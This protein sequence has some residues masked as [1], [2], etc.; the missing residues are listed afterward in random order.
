MAV[1]KQQQRMAVLGL[2]AIG[3][4]YGWQM[5]KFAADTQMRRWMPLGL[6]TIYKVLKDLE[7]DGAV[8]G[9]QEGGGRGPKR[10]AHVLTERGRAEFEDGVVTAL[11]SDGSVY[12]DRMAGLVFAPL[13]RESMALDAM[14]DADD[15]LASAEVALT[16]SAASTGT[17]V[18]A[19]AIITFYREVHAA[20][21]K[22]LARVKGFLDDRQPREG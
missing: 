6:S 21:R 2:L 3:M 17:D 4:R 8:E 13:L 16:D 7:R 22:A 12:S 11:R 14:Q 10:K 15:W 20:E 1:R 19:D 9:A 5:E 18:V